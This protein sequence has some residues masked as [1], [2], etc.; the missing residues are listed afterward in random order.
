L[1]CSSTHLLSVFLL[2]RQCRVAA[3]NDLGTG[4]GTTIKYVRRTASGAVGNGLGTTTKYLRR[5][6]NGAA[7]SGRGTTIKYLWRVTAAGNR[8]A[9]TIKYLR[10]AASIGMG[11]KIKCR[12]MCLCVN[13]ELPSC[14]HKQ[15]PHQ[16][17][18]PLA[19]AAQNNI[20]ISK[21]KGKKHHVSPSLPPHRACV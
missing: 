4:L 18:F 15:K 14:V 17:T 20:H 10:G 16:H 1:L 21:R 3:G 7:G 13:P 19:S 6:R 12:A 9:T 8:L 11:T 2:L 5:T